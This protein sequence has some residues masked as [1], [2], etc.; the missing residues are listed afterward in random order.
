MSIQIWNEV[1]RPPWYVQE[2]T[3][4]KS[5]LNVGALSLHPAGPPFVY[6]DIGSNVILAFWFEGF[7]SPL[8]PSVHGI[9]LFLSL[10]YSLI[11]SSLTMVSQQP[12]PIQPPLLASPSISRRRRPG[13]AMVVNPHWPTSL[14]SRPQESSMSRL[15]VVTMTAVIIFLVLASGAIDMYPM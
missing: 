8:P 13:Q 1:Y 10:H 2:Y 4:G 3:G 9:K 5:L 15:Y 11:A 7:I 12:L 6:S 14:I